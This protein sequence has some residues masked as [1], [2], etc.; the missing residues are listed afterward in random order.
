MNE[1][2]TRPR[3][4][5]I[6]WLAALAVV[7]FSAVG[8]AAVTGLIPTAGGHQELSAESRMT[9]A[10]ASTKPGGAK[11]AKPARQ[12]S[13]AKPAP[14][15]VA[16]GHCGV[17]ESV[18]PVQVDGQGSGAGVVAGGV[19]GGVLG[20]R[21]GKGLG[22]DLATLGGAVLGGF[23]GNQIEKKVNSGTAYEVSVRLDDGR[24]QVLRLE[25]LPEL[26]AGDRVALRDG[27]LQP[28][29]KGNG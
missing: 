16:C 24:R 15:A 8:I 1:N 13:A 3:L 26:R 9:A 6:Q 25:H 21:V 28:L 11:A 22:R 14:T 17:I 7:G 20:N 12:T 29:P 2:N 10:E 23:A 27:T 4:H 5:P 19:V 18:T